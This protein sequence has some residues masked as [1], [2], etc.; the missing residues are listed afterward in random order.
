MEIDTL[1]ILPSNPEP[2]DSF[3]LVAHT[4]FTQQ[5]CSL[6]NYDLNRDNE[7]VKVS[8]EY[9]PGGAPSPITCVDTFAIETFEVGQFD[10]IYEVTHQQTE[11]YK[12]DTMSFQVQQPNAILER[13]VDRRDGEIIYP[14]PADEKIRF[15]APSIIKEITIM[16]KQGRALLSREPHGKDGYLDITGL[17]KG[18]YLVLFKYSNG[19]GSKAKILSVY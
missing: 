11:E 13:D 19:K 1:Y 16:D 14:N 17:E 6:A 10:L 9:V 7:Q 2:E 3:E 18:N 15:E 4:C 12:R 8:A 5:P